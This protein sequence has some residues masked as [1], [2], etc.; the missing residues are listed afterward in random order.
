MAT[1]YKAV[2]EGRRRLP[3]HGRDQA[4][5]ARVPRAQELHRHVHR[6]GARRQRARA[7]E[8]RP[9]PRLRQ[10]GRLVLPGHG[11]GR[12]HR[13]RRASSRSTA[14]R[15]T[16]VPWP[17]AVA[18]GIGTLRGLGAAHDRRRA[19]RHAGAGHPPRRLA[20]QRAARHQRRGQALRLRPRAGARSRREPD[21]ARH[22]QGQAA[23]P[24]ARGHV[25]Q[26]EHARSRDLFGVG[27]VLWETL[28]GERL[29]DGKN[30]VEIFKKIRA[31]KVPPIADAPPRHPAGARRGARGRARGRSGEPLR[32][33]DRVRVTRSSR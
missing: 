22:R 6:G 25:R 16:Q 8:H 18:I 5:Q 9:G 30:D 11:V 15:G 10:R 14:T 4:H 2:A 24:R 33:R 29:F 19:R 32:D 3:A 17:L 7:P 27:S 26:A 1:V 13:P 21:R 31:C 28:T 12:G 20:A 23:V